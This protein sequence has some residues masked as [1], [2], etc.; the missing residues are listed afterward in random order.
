MASNQRFTVEEALN[1][2]F[3][4]SDS[5]MEEETSGSDGQSDSYNESTWNQLPKVKWRMALMISTQTCQLI[6]KI[7]CEHKEVDLVSLMSEK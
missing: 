7:C 6:R 4:D 3:G 2:A 5:E 1:A